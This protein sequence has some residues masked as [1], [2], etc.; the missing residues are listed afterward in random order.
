MEKRTVRTVLITG[1]SD[2]GLGAALAVAF[3]K[4]RSYRVF[5]TARNTD[6]MA[7]LT[8]LGIETLELDVTSEESIKACVDKVSSL[9]GGTLDVL[10]NNA[11]AAYNI[12]ILDASLPEIRKQ[13]DLNVF[14]PV[15]LIQAFF[16]LL[17]KS[18]STTKLIV[19][20]TSCA[21]VLAFPFIGPY[22]ASKSTL[23]SF[24]ET[25]RLELQPFN[26]KVVDLKTA[27]VQSHFFDNVKNQALVSTAPT[28]PE[29]SP[30]APGKDV[31]EKFMRDGPSVKL[32]DADVWAKEIVR[33]LSK[34]E[35]RR[36]PNRVWRGTGAFSAWFA[37]AAVPV[38]WLDGTIKKFSGLDIV[39]KR[40]RDEGRKM[41]ERQ[42]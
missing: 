10:V 27:G 17:R 35:G 13:F 32:M 9:T 24:S 20:N 26:I 7:H 12:P 38:G 2:G 39:E 22:T 4:H 23:S 11:G 28:L 30:Y 40:V 42:Q 6:K 16:P 15:L 19:N 34:G 29:T 21:P 1:C 8:S 41:T 14:G 36:A 3:Q 5:A 33:D 18:T 37:S 25:L 31:V